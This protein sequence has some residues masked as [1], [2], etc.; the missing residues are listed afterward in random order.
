MERALPPSFSK[1]CPRYNRITLLGLLTPIGSPRLECP[2]PASSFH[3]LSSFSE[4]F[5]CT[6]E[7]LGSTRGQRAVSPTASSNGLPLR[8]QHWPGGSANYCPPS[9]L[10]KERRLCS[11]HRPG[12]PDRLLP[13][14]VLSQRKPSRG[15]CLCVGRGRDQPGATSSR[16]MS[17]SRFPLPLLF[18]LLLR[19]PF[20]FPLPTSFSLYLLFTAARI[21]QDK[22]FSLASFHS[23]FLSFISFFL[24]LFTSFLFSLSLSSSLPSSIPSFLSPFL[25]FL[26]VSLLPSSPASV[27]H[28]PVPS[29]TKE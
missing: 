14:E 19:L 20:L 11:E 9:I 28:N 15:G 24:Q 23:F 21:L 6:D 13:P 3:V 12:Q 22:L 7:A 29:F 27:L 17:A 25:S 26:L 18:S 10:Q 1:P 5:K 4:K 16:S 8:V 2:P